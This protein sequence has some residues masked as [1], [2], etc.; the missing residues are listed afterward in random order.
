MA[1][2]TEPSTHGAEGSGVGVVVVPTPLIGGDEADVAP[3]PAP[4]PSA[5]LQIDASGPE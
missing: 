3:L 5:Q 2:A 4:N 1:Q